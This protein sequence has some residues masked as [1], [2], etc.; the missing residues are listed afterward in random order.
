MNQKSIL[1][2]YRARFFS[3]FAKKETS[4]STITRH[5]KK[6]IGIKPITF[7]WCGRRDL[8]SYGVN[9]TPLKR[10]RLPVP[11]LP[12]VVLFLTTGLLYTIFRKSQGVKGKKFWA[13]KDF[14]ENLFLAV[15][16]FVFSCYNTPCSGC[17]AVGSAPG[18]G[19]GCRR[20]KSCHSD[21]KRKCPLWV[22]PL[23]LGTIGRAEMRCRFALQN[24][25]PQGFA[26]FKS[27]HS[28]QK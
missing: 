2:F 24:G 8:N 5:N 13:K 4:S 12:R 16:F 21:Q 23:L 22:L 26:E 15:D 19:P 1:S 25:T 7:L 10:A 17:S 20:F 27:C 28:D 9:H 18:L 6:V 14:F 11:P 3:C